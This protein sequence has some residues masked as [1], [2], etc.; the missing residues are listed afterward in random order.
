MA[1]MELL[2]DNTFAPVKFRPVGVS[3]RRPSERRQ[4]AYRVVWLANRPFEQAHAE[5]LRIFEQSD[6]PVM[7]RASSQPLPRLEE[8][9]T[10]H[11]EGFPL[12]SIPDRLLSIEGAD[13]KERLLREISVALENYLSARDTFSRNKAAVRPRKQVAREPETGEL[14][15]G[16]RKAFMDAI[17][18]RGRYDDGVR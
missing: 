14:S 1:R 10:L 18:G 2:L 9:N 6:I 7:V 16:E 3:S 8:L 4:P 13:G 5:A 12:V 17:S 15:D 11:D